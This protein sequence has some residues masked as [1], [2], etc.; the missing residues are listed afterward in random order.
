MT[1]QLTPAATLPIWKKSDRKLI[2]LLV[3]LSA[4]TLMAMLISIGYGE[5]PIAPLDVIKTILGLPTANSD[6]GFIINSLRLPRVLVAFLVGVV[7]IV[8]I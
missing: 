4:I 1:K 3:I 5:Y 7:F 6:Y 2:R 8:Y